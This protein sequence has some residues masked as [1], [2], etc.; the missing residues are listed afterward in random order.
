MTRYH[1]R[2]DGA[3]AVCT[4]QAGNCPLGDGT[5]HF[6]SYKEAQVFADMRNE[7]LSH[8]EEYL[9]E[10]KELLRGYRGRIQEIQDID[11]DMTRLL[12]I[13][14]REEKD[15]TNYRERWDISG[16]RNAVSF[17]ETPHLRTG[18]LIRID[19]PEEFLA[20]GTEFEREENRELLRNLIKNK[21][22]NQ[23][24]GDIE[25]EIAGDRDLWY[26]DRF[27]RDP[28]FAS[29][30]F[31]FND[32]NNIEHY[33]ENPMVAERDLKRINDRIPS[34]TKYRAYKGFRSKM[35]DANRT[36]SE[37]RIDTL[38]EMRDTKNYDIIRERPLLVDIDSRESLEASAN[39]RKR[40]FEIAKRMEYLRDRL[41]SIGEDV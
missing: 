18:K 3:P 4:A 17:L 6:N 39:Y 32:L 29:M 26:E 22:D 37:E 15:K 24:Y 9:K 21:I 23:I 10:Y 30:L 8:K 35:L 14:I 36:M 1:I 12:S 2:K 28:K 16:I 25:A 34:Y 41:R 33:K 5:P 38:I 31:T 40:T 19:D 7:A 13:I 20:Y 11:N 27:Y